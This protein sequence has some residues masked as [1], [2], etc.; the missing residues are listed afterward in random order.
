MNLLPLHEVTGYPIVAPA[1]VR[2]RTPVARVNEVLDKLI[3]NHLTI[4]VHER[5][6]NGIAPSFV[7]TDGAG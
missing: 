3:A 7:N 6:E 5:Y 2:S 1:S 4:V